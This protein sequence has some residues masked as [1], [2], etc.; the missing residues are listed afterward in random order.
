MSVFL[1]LPS[2]FLSFSFPFC[3]EASESRGRES[4]GDDLLVYFFPYLPSEYLECANSQISALPWK[5][6]ED[7]RF[8]QEAFEWYWTCF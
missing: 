4:T 3:F 5:L 1:A 6:W 2:E 8:V 7:L